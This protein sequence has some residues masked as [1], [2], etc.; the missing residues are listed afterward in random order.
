M[1]RTIVAAILTLTAA[2]AMFAQG[3]GRP[4][5]SGGT[6]PTPEQMVE[7]RVQMLTNFLTLDTAQQQQAKTIFTEAATASQS[8][9]D[10]GKGAHEALEAA[11]KSGAAD[12]QI[13]Q[14]A[15]QVGVIQGQMTAI[16]AKAQAKFRLILNSAQKEK[17]DSR[18][19]RGGFFGG[20]MGPM[21]R[22][23]AGF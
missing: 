22:G 21:R 6:P 18:E 15:G 7:R 12:A 9:R 23:A 2:S 3:P 17:L 1:K 8:L 4:E 16:Q 5:G 14:L 13:D 19:G 10:S 20:L 11:V